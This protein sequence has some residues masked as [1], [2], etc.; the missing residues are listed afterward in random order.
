VDTGRAPGDGDGKVKAAVALDGPEELVS[1]RWEPGVVLSCRVKGDTSGSVWGS[2][3]Y[4]IDSDLATAAVHAGILK[5]G[6]EGT[7]TVKVVKSPASFHGSEANGVTTKDFGPWPE[8]A[9]IFVTG[10]TVP[11]ADPEQ[12]AA[13]TWKEGS[14]LALLVRGTTSGSVWGSGPYTLDSSV[15]AAAVHAGLLKSGQVGFVTVEVI[16]SPT[17]Y[18]GSTANGVTTLDFARYEPGAFTFLSGDPVKTGDP[19]EITDPEQLYSAQWEAGTVLTCRVKGATSGTVWGSG[20]YTIDS[21]LAAAAV[22]AGL[23]KAG[24]TGTV[25]IKVVRPPASFSGSTA[26]GVTTL[27]YGPYFPGAFIFLKGDKKQG[28]EKLPDPGV[29]SSYSGQKGQRFT[30]Q[31]TGTTTGPVWGSGPYTL[32]ST[33]A[34]AAVHA[35]L[36]K[37]GQTGTVTVEI[38]ASPDGY[39]GSTANGV[40]TES[41][42]PWPAGAFKFIK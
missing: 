28:S 4:S 14:V 11:L 16:K 7:V 38:M 19:I 13:G 10:R 17:A 9:F 32:D 40:A 41:Y 12:F 26:H 36:V 39:S 21:P 31:V 25:T 24:E 1:K 29:L 37:D 23:L 18:R 8:G 42:G 35:G 27:D 6:Q 2:G 20:P 22:H 34:A 5:A 30:F 33:L 3:P 15:G